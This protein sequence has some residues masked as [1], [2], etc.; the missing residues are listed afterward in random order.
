MPKRLKVQ[1][2]VLDCEFMLKEENEEENGT[3]AFSLK[4]AFRVPGVHSCTGMTII[5]ILYSSIL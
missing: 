4:N 2:Q 5:V 3:Q 1:V